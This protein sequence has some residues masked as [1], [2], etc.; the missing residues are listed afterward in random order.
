VH[1]FWYFALPAIGLATLSLRGE[2]RRAEYVT[3]RLPFPE[4]AATPPVTVIAAEPA[5]FASQDYPDFE[6]MSQE[7]FAGSE[8]APRAEST[9]YVFAL[10]PGRVRPTFLRAIVAGLA[11]PGAAASTAFRWYVPTPPGFWPLLASVWDA[12]IAGRLGPGASE[13]AWGGACA[14]A[15]DV[16]ERLPVTP[17]QDFGLA[18]WRAV[19]DAGM[20]VAFAPGAMVAVERP[21]GMVEFLWRSRRELA[22]A[23]RSVPGLWWRAL[24]AHTLYCAGLTATIAAIV[25]GSGLAEWALIPQL[26]IGMLKGANRSTLGKAELPGYKAWFDRYSWVHS[27]WVPIATWLWLLLLAASAFPATPRPR[28][29][30]R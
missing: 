30:G 13:F 9:V 18:L 25:S 29:N 6:V 22:I 23:R 27:L 1:W 17:Q 21:V 20:H 14:V 12:V 4:N 15:K 19:C 7:E 11:E 16:F 26:G 28:Y 10:E 3:A 8:R 5:Q 24:G 2:R